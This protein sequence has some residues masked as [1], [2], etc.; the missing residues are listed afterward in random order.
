MGALNPYRVLGIDPHAS[1]RDIRRAYH[2]L[3]LRY[4][5][6]AAADESGERFV[7]IHEAYRLLSDPTSRADYDREHRDYSERRHRRAFTQPMTLSSLFADADT[8]LR[9]ALEMLDLVDLGFV[10]EG[11][12]RPAPET[13]H[14]ELQLSPLEAERGGRMSFV[15]PGNVEIELV[16]PPGVRDGARAELPLESGLVDVIVRVAR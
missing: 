16:V 4:H 14:Y 7:E 10:H 3:A 2:T 5:P 11:R 15:I 12:R 1:R 8:L 6:D 9:G 13:L